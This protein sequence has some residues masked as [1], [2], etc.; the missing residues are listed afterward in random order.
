LYDGGERAAT[1]KREKAGVESAGLN[2]LAAMRNID[3]EI[4]SIYIN[5]LYSREAIAVNRSL[6]EVSRAQEERGK[7]LM[8]SGRLALPDYARLQ[9]QAEAD[10]YN[11]VSAEASYATQRMQ[12]K[13]VLE[14]GLNTVIEIEPVEF[15]D[16]DVTD[17]LPDIDESFRM[18]L[19]EDAALRAAKVRSQMAELD[20]AVARA[21]GLPSISL[22]AGVGSGYYTDR[23][24]GWSN[25]MKR[26]LNEQIGV[27]LAVPIFNQKSTKTA[28]AKAK[29]TQID[30]QLE[31]DSR[32]VEISQTLEG[33]YI[34][35]ESA[36]SRY[37]AGLSQLEAAS[38]SSDLLNRKFEVGY[39]E[40]TELLQAHSTLASARHEL[41]Q[42]KYMAVLARKMVQYMRTSSV[43]I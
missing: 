29:V 1:I 3:T 19:D 23:T 22:Q 27:T 4:L 10:R 14:L 17:P 12:L 11:V 30:S 40:I 32:E 21:S 8:E 43:I 16:T 5:L 33:W 34:D 41:L 36:R 20:V 26:G 25:Q 28:V 37:E 31:A 18:A 35:M 15:A 38:L 9:A 2:T 24:G 39:V 6:A 13:R 42:A 7:T